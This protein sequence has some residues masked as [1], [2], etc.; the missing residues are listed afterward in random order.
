MAD[1][2]VVAQLVREMMPGC[3]AERRLS[4]LYEG[5]P[6]GHALTWLACADGEVAGCTSFFPFRL[7]LD[8]A[9]ALA[10]LGGDGW[11]RPAYRRHG[12]GAALHEASRSALGGDGLACMY[13]APGSMNLSPLKH[14]GIAR[15]RARCRGG[16][17]RCVASA[18]CSR[19]SS[20]RRRDPVAAGAARA[21]AAARP[22][23]RRGLAGHARRAAR[24]APC[25]MPRST[26]GGFSSRPS[27]REPAYVIVTA[28]S[29][30]SP[31][32]RSTRWRSAAI[33]GSSI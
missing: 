13:G 2:D 15:G 29:A 32:A 24:S 5:N 19:G 22:A 31:R 9:Q 8:G 14:G 1:R 6:A 12:I 11:V 4:W 10:A 3:D 20:A 21:D 30:R 27:S 33:C 26:R 28:A 23:R 16:C 25:A 17:V 18:P 7:Q